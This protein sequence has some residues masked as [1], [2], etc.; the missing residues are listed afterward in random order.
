MGKECNILV[1][2]SNAPMTKSRS[3]KLDE[4]S[5]KFGYLYIS[6]DGCTFK[7]SASDVLRQRRNVIKTEIEHGDSEV[8]DGAP[9]NG[10]TNGVLIE[11]TGW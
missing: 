8:S 1:E 3:P 10:V 2:K 5:N 9:L 4:V 11:W 7:T 6:K